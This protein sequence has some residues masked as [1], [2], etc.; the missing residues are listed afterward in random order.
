[1]KLTGSLLRA[2]LLGI[3]QGV[4]EFLPIS[5]SGHLVLVPWLLRWENPG[6]A[7]DAMLHLG[8]LCAV[9]AFF[10]RDLWG[11]VVAGLASIRERSLGEDPRRKLAWCVVIGT[12][13]AA[14]VGF[15]FNDLVEALFAVPVCAGALLLV[16]GA[17]LAM[18]ER[19]SRL[20]A[21]LEGID[22]LD[23]LIV[24]LA[25]ALAIAPGISRSGATMSAG[26]WRGLRREAAAR[27]SFLLSTPIILGAGVYKLKDLADTALAAQSPLVLVAGFLAAAISGFLSI[28]FLLG[29]LRKGRLYPFAIYCWVAGSAVL[30]LAVL[31]IR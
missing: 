30:L 25:Q 26:L 14:V 20:V 1:V 5:S 21:G 8:S 2:L 13:P 11:L 12:V 29:Y 6:L 24:G 17:L 22:W 27:F 10:W 9:V 31:S 28:R 23:A 3:V 18:S 16:T 15:L 4:T 19:R 7:F